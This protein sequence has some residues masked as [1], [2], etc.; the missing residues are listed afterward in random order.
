MTINDLF[1]A[2]VTP[3]LATNLIRIIKV[4]KVRVRVS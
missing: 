3:Y 4:C 2:T 1:R